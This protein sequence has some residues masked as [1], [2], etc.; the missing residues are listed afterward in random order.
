VLL[1]LAMWMTPALLQWPIVGLLDLRI[2]SDPRPIDL[3]VNSRYFYVA[4]AGALIALAGFFSPLYTTQRS[5]VRRCISGSVI[6]LVLVGLLASQHLARSYR[7]ET[8]QQRTITE[9]A[10]AAIEQLELPSQGCQIYLLDTNN[11]MFA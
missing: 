11:W 7:N 9:A 4:L 2:G 6:A 1:G 10:V 3:V 8:L 5:L